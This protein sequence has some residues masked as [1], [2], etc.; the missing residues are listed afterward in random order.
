MQ[1]PI[2]WL[3]ILV[4]G[5]LLIAPG[6]AARLLVDVVEGFALLLVFG[7]LVLAG[8]GFLAWQWFRRR[9]ITCPACGTPSLGASL[10][11]ACG[12][13]LKPVESGTSASTD[14]PASSAVI[15]V[16]VKDVSDEP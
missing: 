14:Q 4:I 12:T 7:P 16:Q 6:F 10:C 9:L 5:V 15:D 3:W 11:P 8:A 1:R 13:S 2:P